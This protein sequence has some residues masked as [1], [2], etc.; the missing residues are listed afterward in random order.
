MS[1]TVHDVVLNATYSYEVLAAQTH[2]LVPMD[3]IVRCERVAKI[4]V[5]VAPIALPF[6]FVESVS[7]LPMVK[8][9]VMPDFRLSI[10]KTTGRRTSARTTRT[11]CCVS[12]ELGNDNDAADDAYGTLFAA[13][14]HDLKFRMTPASIML[15]MDLEFYAFPPPDFYIV[16]HCVNAVPVGALPGLP[17]A[18]QDHTPIDFLFRP[19]K[20]SE[21][22]KL[23]MDIARDLHKSSAEGKAQ[24]GDGEGGGGGAG[25]GVGAGVGS[26]SSD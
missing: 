19:M 11:V 8:G 25:A 6:G 5:G 23:A 12:A 24:D 15:S 4:V 3:M 26:G 14:G 22:T 9:V 21:R 17:Q 2:A 18:L 13:T 7:V 10:T 20:P 16:Y 1:C